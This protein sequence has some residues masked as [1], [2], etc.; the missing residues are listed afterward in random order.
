MGNQARGTFQEHFR[1]LDQ[2]RSGQRWAIDHSKQ[3]WKL[4]FFM[5]DH[6]NEVLFTTSKLDELSGNSLVKIAIQKER[7]LGLGQLDISFQ[8]YLSLPLSSFS[9]MKSIDLRR[10]LCLIRQAREDTGT[11]YTDKIASDP[12]L[13]EWVGLNRNNQEPHS[14]NGTQEQRSQ[15]RF[16][17]TGYME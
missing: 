11:R 17:T 8:P 16:D 7:G 3:L 15:L 14:T 12:A 2:W 5:W 13:R 6:P 4:V 10:W 1:A 9:K